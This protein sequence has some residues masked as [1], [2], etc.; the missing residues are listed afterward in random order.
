MQCINYKIRRILVGCIL[1]FFSA[2]VFATRPIII[3]TD[4]GVDDAIAILY[5]LK[6]PDVDVKAITVASDGN[7]HCEPALANTLGLVA[8]SDTSAI[9]VACG[10][11]QPL[12]GDH[13]FPESVL[14][15]S[16]TLNHTAHLLPP[17]KRHKKLVARDLLLD[18]LSTTSS[19]IDILAIGPLTNLAEVLLENPEV[20]NNIRMIYVMGGAIQV[21]GNIREVNPHIKNNVSEWNF[22][23]DPL[24]ADIVFRSGVPITLIP[25][26][27]TNQFPIDMQFYQQTK[28]LKT[29]AGRYVHQLF[30]NNLK[31]LQAKKWYF[32]DPLAA[33]IATDGSIARCEKKKLR[34][35]LS[36]EEKSGAIVIDK[37]NGNAVQVCLKASE[38]KFKNTLRSHW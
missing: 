20:K 18:L 31:E 29:P 27:L 23:I 12:S 16:D 38:R 26:D 25:L 22:Y 2:V 11:E 1:C 32:W 24:A 8:L 33:V 4:V 36:P 9:P 17:F 6:R 21:P 28:L 15:E 7:A 35:L 5:L 13:R 14:Q 37:K 30:K 19:P 10:R 34:V 3:D